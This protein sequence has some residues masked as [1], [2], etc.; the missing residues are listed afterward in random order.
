MA[1]IDKTY[2]SSWREFKEIKDWAIKTNVIYPNGINGGKMINWIYYPDLTEKDFLNNNEHVLWNTSLAVDV[3]LYKNCPFKLIQDRL[4]EQY[5]NVSYLN[6]KS[7]NEHEIGN[8]FT[9]PS[10]YTSYSKYAVDLIYNNN[11]WWY[12]EKT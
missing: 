8:H 12:S 7:I 10:V 3:F 2:I 11:Y 6:K 4:K 9:L 5:G 1:G